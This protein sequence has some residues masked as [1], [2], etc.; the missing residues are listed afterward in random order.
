MVL[1]AVALTFSFVLHDDHQARGDQSH[2]EAAPE[3]RESAYV[4]RSESV[5]N[6]PSR[7]QNVRPRPF[8]TCPKWNMIKTHR[9]EVTTESTASIF[10]WFWFPWRGENSRKLGEKPVKPSKL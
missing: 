2:L 6:V 4:V 7:T 5:A 1:V 3:N 8:Q 9:P 10:L